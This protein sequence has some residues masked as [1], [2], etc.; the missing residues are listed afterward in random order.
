[1]LVVFS[2]ILYTFLALMLI[3]E[4]YHYCCK[5]NHTTNILLSPLCKIFRTKF[6]VFNHVNI[7][8]NIPRFFEN[9]NQSS[10]VQ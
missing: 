9:F 5:A 7:L 6:V 10:T 3:G 1:M 2:V 4:K 8:R